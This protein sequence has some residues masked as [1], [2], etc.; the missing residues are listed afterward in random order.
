MRS[1][2]YLLGFAFKLAAAL[3]TTI[4]TARPDE[5]LDLSSL[6]RLA[7][8][9]AAQPGIDLSPL[10]QLCEPVDLSA[11]DK[12]Q[13]VVSE[14]AATPKPPRDRRPVVWMYKPVTV[15]PAC[16]RALA[17]AAKPEFPARLSVKTGDLPTWA[18][19][20]PTTNAYPLF[21]WGTPDGKGRAKAGYDGIEAFRTM[22][23]KPVAK[24]EKST[25]VTRPAY[26]T[27]CATGS[28]R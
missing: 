1:S 23:S 14:P 5:P 11:L 22:L 20:K 27:Y 4:G 12:L 28:C 10:D 18:K 13:L 17:D 7:P 24:P 9:A 2:I 21:W 25:R 6:D 3:L 19:S 26:R 16:N 15:C 8:P